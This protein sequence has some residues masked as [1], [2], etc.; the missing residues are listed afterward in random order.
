MTSKGSTSPELLIELD[1]SRPRGLRAQVEDGLRTAIRDGRLAP[2]TRL[3][4][5]R[6][7]AA[8]LSVMRGVVVTA[9]EQLVAEGYLIAG[10]GRGRS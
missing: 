2:G 4:S 7:L 8:D 1:R 9:Y 10:P 6:A 3:P 5:T